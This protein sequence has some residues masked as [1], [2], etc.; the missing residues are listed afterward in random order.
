MPL[1][2]KRDLNSLLRCHYGPTLVIALALVAVFVY[3]SSGAT[4]LPP[5]SGAAVSGYR[6]AGNPAPPQQIPRF[7]CPPTGNPYWAYARYK[8]RLDSLRDRT[9][10]NN[11][12]TA[13]SR[14][15]AYSQPP[16]A[17]HPNGVGKALPAEAEYVSPQ[18]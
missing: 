16:A 3:R 7:V 12:S 17:G 8:L 2:S 13:H 6:Q 18:K 10:W 11:P 15:T 1:Y 4:D 5:S 14:A 9:G